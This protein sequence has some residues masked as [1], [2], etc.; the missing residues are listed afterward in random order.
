M[1]D[2]NDYREYRLDVKKRLNIPF[3]KGQ[4]DMKK[5]EA[6]FKSN[7]KGQVSLPL[8]EERVQILEKEYRDLEKEYKKVIKR[9]ESTSDC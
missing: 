7:D 8:Q 6:V 4:N 1:T 5:V 3:K 2:D 9:L